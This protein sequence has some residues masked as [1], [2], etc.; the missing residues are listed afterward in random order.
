MY[1]EER[2]E[3]IDSLP[4]LPLQPV[5]DELIITARSLNNAPPH[6]IN[7]PTAS[8][9]PE[10]I[11]AF[12]PGVSQD[13]IDDVNLCKLV[14]QNAAS[15]LYPN[16]AQL[17][18]WYKYYVNGLDKLGWVVQNQNIQEVTIKKI[19]LTMDQVAL[20]VA[21]SLIGANA[22]GVLANVAKQALDHVQKNPRA[23]EIFNRN[24]KIGQ[25]A[26]FDIAPVWV[27][28]NNQPNMVLNCISLDARESNRGILFWKSTTH[29]TTIKSG[30]VRS[31]LDNKVFAGL[32]DELYGKYTEAGK[33]FIIDLPDF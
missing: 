9:M 17:F 6:D 25:Q 2:L 32:R 1:L 18:E 22:A 30:A 13:I 8:V 12:M 16:D 26:K 21:I 28:K 4:A 14:M 33:K 3:F 7:K 19:G 20:E 10:T 31:Y 29:S 23:I 15:K 27:D 5:S 24:S 11:D